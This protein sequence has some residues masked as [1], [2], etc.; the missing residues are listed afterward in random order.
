M[1]RYGMVGPSSGQLLTYQGKALV[2]DD[3]D[4][5]TW[6]F[7]RV[8]VV[9]LSDG[10]LGQPEMRLQDHPGLAQVRFPLRREDF[11]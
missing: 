11:P 2:H 5:M 4:E 3:R 7:P 1:S 10:D 8:R 9:R 6:L